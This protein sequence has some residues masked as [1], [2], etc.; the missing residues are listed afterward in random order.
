MDAHITPD[1][2][3]Q[4]PR[5]ASLVDMAHEELLRRITDGLLADGDRIVIDQLARDL[6][7]SLIPVREALARLHAEGLV[8]FERNKGYRVAPRPSVSELRRLFEARLVLEQGACEL[9]LA[10][11]VPLALGNLEAVNKLISRGAYG[12]TFR[13]FREFVTLNE[14]FHSELVA[15]SDNPH[16]EEAYRRLG[17]HQQITRPTYGHG[18]PDL[19]L[20][21]REHEAILDALRRADVVEV[22]K[23]LREHILG[24][25][26][27]LATVLGRSSKTEH[28][29]WA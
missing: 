22:R 25:H 19:D 11:G 3:A 29:H 18:V 24:G 13:G 1:R 12:T 16:L 28:G 23:A 5:G 8:T 9:A 4:L 2:S 20:I 14:R 26:D 27:R 15:L 17:Y 21:V 10:R 6:S 7:I